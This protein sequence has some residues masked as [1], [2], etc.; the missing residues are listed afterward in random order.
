MKYLDLGS[1][2][3]LNQ[4]IAIAIVFIIL[5]VVLIFFK[6][7][8]S[9]GFVGLLCALSSYLGI[10]EY[11]FYEVPVIATTGF[12]LSLCGFTHSNWLVKIFS[13]IGAIVSGYVLLHAFGI[14]V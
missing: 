8:F 2:T 7:I 13:I 4:V 6:S 9:V 10:F 3:G 11:H 12:I 14:I 5:F 1:L